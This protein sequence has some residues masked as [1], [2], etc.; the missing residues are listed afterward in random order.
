[1]KQGFPLTLI[2]ILMLSACM[3]NERREITAFY[4]VDSLIDQ[5]ILALTSTY[6][7][8]SKTGTVDGENGD[9]RFTPD[10]V[11]W[12]RELGM[13]RTL[14]LNQPRLV[15]MYE[16]S[17]RELP[18]GKVISY[19]SKD[20]ENTRVNWV[21]IEQLGSVVTLMRGELSE[22]NPVYGTTRQIG[23]NFTEDGLI[24]EYF[25]RGGEKLSL[26]D[27]LVYLMNASVQWD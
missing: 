18:D 15:E 19:T 25:I 4:R 12:Q 10:S 22:K 26:K 24:N 21:E 23:M 17:T 16:I 9:V 2:L 6:P 13:F 1:M 7:T 27:S 14:D 8:L 3:Q 11:T 5:Q 20:P